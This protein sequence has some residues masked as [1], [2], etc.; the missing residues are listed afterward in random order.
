MGKVIKKCLACGTLNQY[1]AETCKKCDCPLLA[2]V[3]QE[4]EILSIDPMEAAL[5]DAVSS[6][7]Q[8]DDLVAQILREQAEN[9]KKIVAKEMEKEER[10][11]VQ[12]S[13][14]KSSPFSVSS[15]G[16]GFSLG[17]E[18]N[19]GKGMPSSTPSSKP[20][21]GGSFSGFKISDSTYQVK[22]VQEPGRVHL[23]GGSLRMQAIRKSQEAQGSEGKK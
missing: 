12:N 2:D 9:A 16:G 21:G 19:K 22:D 1:E 4:D 5:D 10:K 23:G 8:E 20:S 17:G 6:A 18:S 3:D 11:N 15:G 13:E 14:Q 7:D